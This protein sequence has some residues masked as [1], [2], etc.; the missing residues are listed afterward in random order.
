MTQEIRKRYEDA[1]DTLRAIVSR[2]GVARDR[3]RGLILDAA[4]RI[5]DALERG[6]DIEDIIKAFRDAVEAYPTLIPRRMQ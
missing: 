4:S 3:I 2:T 5:A 6:E 1:L